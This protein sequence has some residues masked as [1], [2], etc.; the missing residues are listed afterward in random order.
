M[1]AYAAVMTPGYPVA[2][3]SGNSVAVAAGC[4][5]AIAAALDCKR[6]GG[7]LFDAAI[8][9]AAVQSVVMPEATSLGGDL[10][11]LVRHGGRTVSVNATGAAPQAATIGAFHER[12][13]GA[14]PA[15]GPLSVQPPGMVA[16]LLKLHELG[17]SKM[18]AELLEPAIELADRGCPVSVRLAEALDIASA[19]HLESPAWRAIYAPEGRPL[20]A[21]ETLRQPALARSL[22]AIG[23]KG[24][25]AFYSG[26][27]ARDIVNTLRS[28]GGLLCEADLADVRAKIVEPLR[29]RFR[30]Y[31]ISTE[32]PV[33]QG[34][35]LLRALR[36]LEASIHGG[37]AVSQQRLWEIAAVCLRQG[38][39]ER[40][41]LIGDGADSLA[42]SLLEE[43]AAPGY[44]STA[45]WFANQ[46][47]D[48]TTLSITDGTDAIALIQSIYADLGSG[49]VTPET[50]IL[51][52]NRLSGFFLDRHHPN[53]LKPGRSTMHTLHSFM[54]ESDNGLCWA[55]G[56]P[57]G[58]HQPQVN[59]QVI[60]RLL[61]L[62]QRP[63]VA[64]GAPRW[65]TTPGTRP[66][67][68]RASKTEFYY[69]PGVDQ[70]LIK[71]V[72]ERGWSVHHTS[73]PIG[74]SKVVGV[75]A[76]KTLGGWAD[77]RR[78][79]AAGAY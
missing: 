54:V 30:Q 63:E 59:L 42:R 3:A 43:D 15:T 19:E 14:V 31:Q 21:G 74:S 40:L 9:G 37:D 73:L 6:A 28:G 66:I 79:G 7:N 48:T 16:G 78:H 53:G 76:P 75:L 41:R 77:S 26:E 32:P 23:E 57:G 10:F 39:A 67:E 65:T 64:M 58:D 45:R 35:I 11:A 47:S 70:G 46:G 8:S 25:A 71:A 60:L 56:T 2:I 13:F 33:S 44:A 17:A 55:G 22:R 4:A 27:I 50:G 69:E 24:V 61:L 5:Q 34:F 29:V 12:G 1:D 62:G 18:L 72:A 52:N 38:F 36:L 49:V 20:K 68:S 51:L